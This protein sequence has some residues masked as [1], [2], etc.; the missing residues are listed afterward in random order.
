MTP[1]PL[2][3]G[4]ILA[5]FLQY[6]IVVF[7]FETFVWDSSARSHPLKARYPL[8]NITGS[9]KIAMSLD[10]ISLR[11]G[12]NT[13][14][15]WYLMR[16]VKF[17]WKDKRMWKCWRLRQGLERKIFSQ[18]VRGSPIGRAWNGMQMRARARA[19]DRPESKSQK[20]S[21]DDLCEDVWWW[22]YLNLATNSR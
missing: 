9:Y 14:L 3:L 1:T 22:G 15:E 17:G 10:H 11:F 7:D 5:N 2:S 20:K 13:S 16:A 12:L 8:P 18:N 21:R 6:L 19:R 4:K